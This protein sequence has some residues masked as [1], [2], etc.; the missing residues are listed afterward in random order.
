MT[1]NGY[2]PPEI[3]DLTIPQEYIDAI[4]ATDSRI[5]SQMITWREYINELQGG[6]NALQQLRTQM[7]MLAE[8]L[9]RELESHQLLLGRQK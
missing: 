2:T 1:Q 9:K 6:A 3:F 5:D 8:P 4:S 7:N